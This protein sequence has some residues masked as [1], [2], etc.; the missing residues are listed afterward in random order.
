MNEKL[1]LL[2]KLAE[3]DR[4]LQQCGCTRINLHN[5]KISKEKS[6]MTGFDLQ[7][8]NVERFVNVYLWRLI[9][10]SM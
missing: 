7:N 3:N 8:K 2:L 5:R 10:T 4:Y 9:E 6:N 1:Q